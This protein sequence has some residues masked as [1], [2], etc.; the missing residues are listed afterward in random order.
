MWYSGPLKT[1]LTL[2]VTLIMYVI[3]TSF[4]NICEMDKRTQERHLHRKGRVCTHNQC[5][6]RNLRGENVRRTQ[7][8]GANI[9]VPLWQVFSY[10]QDISSVKQWKV[11]EKYHHML[12]KW[13]K[14]ISA[15]VTRINSYLPRFTSLTP[16]IFLIQVTGAEIILSHLECIWQYYSIKT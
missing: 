6:A 13:D 11:W 1:H 15:H 4:P 7:M 16:E 12:S 2:S 3:T 9:H 14:I 5:D 10:F 8:R